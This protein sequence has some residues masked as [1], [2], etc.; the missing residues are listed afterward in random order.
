MKKRIVCT[1]LAAVL[2]MAVFAG[3]GG[4]GSGGNTVVVGVATDLKTLDPGYMYEVYGNMISYATYDMLFRM[5]GN[6]MSKPVPSLAT[7]YTIDG[8]NTVYT[9]TLRDGVKFVSGNPLTSADVV[10][11]IRRVMSLQS[12]T[13]DHVAGISDVTAPDDT[14]VIV[15][16]KEP[17]ASFL[18]KGL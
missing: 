1:L 6:D 17:D 15:T 2:M 12:N 13:K 16:L 9:F 10:W 5:D 11:S 7:D 3:C 14:T 8:T 4:S 18:W